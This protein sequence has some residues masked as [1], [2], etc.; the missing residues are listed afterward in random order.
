MCLGK[1]HQMA[2]F[3]ASQNAR[4]GVGLRYLGVCAGIALMM[5]CCTPAQR[6]RPAPLSLAET[7]SKLEARTLD[8]PGLE[9]FIEKSL[10]RPM[11]W[12]PGVW[13][14][15]LLTLAAFYFNPQLET[16]RDQVAAAQAAI[17][18]AG[19][20]PNPTLSLTPG[21]PSPYL[22]S[23]EFAIPVVT[24]GKRQYQME[25]A[26]NL[27]EAARL[28]LEQTAWTVRSGVRAALLNVLVAERSQALWQA[29]ARLQSER[30]SRLGKQLE[31]GAIA[32]PVVDSARVDLL[33]SQLATRA[34]EG[35]VSQTRAALAAAIGIPV[36]GLGKAQ[37]NWPGFDRLPPITALSAR[38]VQRDAVLNR[39]DVRQALVQYSAA[40]AALQLEIARQHPDFQ[41]GPGYQYEETDNFFAPIFSMT[42]PLFNRNQGPIAEAEARRKQAADNLLAT[43]ARAIAESQQ[44]L[45]QY[46]A[47]YAQLHDAQQ[48]LA[49]LRHVQEPMARQQVAAG[50]TDW[51]SLNSVLLQGTAAAQA[52]LNALFQAQAALGALE[53]AIQKPLE[54][55]DDTPLALPAPA[56]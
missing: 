53:G 35:R 51:L 11:G 47:A 22:M 49:D 21:I 1:D 15:R 39:L 36:A 23:L 32:R 5:T 38:Q 48:A 50:E 27:S 31:A 34:A 52:W 30:L 17:V 33:N 54:R 24:A 46:R 18:T 2:T 10:G 3:Q 13:D 29:E 8:D 14:L 26:K 6:Y 55:E 20:R 37:F 19:M 42:L 28:K 4:K 25:A 12:P 9:A 44:A 43:Q 40:Q 56:K 16:A 45:A 7:A 41:I